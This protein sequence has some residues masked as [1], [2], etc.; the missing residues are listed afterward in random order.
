MEQEIK[1]EK[2][3][4]LYYYEEGTKIRIIKVFLVIGT[5]SHELL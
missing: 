5:D 3:Q 4:R 1:G 2:I